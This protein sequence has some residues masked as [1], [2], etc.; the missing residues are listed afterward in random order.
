MRRRRP[1]QKNHLAV[2]RDLLVRRLF[3]AFRA[4]VRLGYFSFEV[5]GLE[6]VPRKGRVVYAQNHAGWFALDAFIL[7]LAVSKAHGIRRAPFFAAHDAALALPV[8]GSFMRRIGALPASSFRRPERLPPEVESVGIFPEGVEG[9]CKPF[10]EAYRMREWNRG[11][12]RVAMARRAPIVPVAMLGGE[13]S[14]P[15]AWT[16]KVLEPLIGAIVG[17][18]LVPIPLPARWKVIFHEPV[19]VSSRRRGAHTDQQFFIDVAKNIR[20]TV[21]ATLD[22]NAAQYPLGRLSSLVAAWRRPGSAAAVATEP[23]RG[24]GRSPAVT[25]HDEQGSLDCSDTALAREGRASFRAP[26]PLRGARRN[27]RFRT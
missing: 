9:N 11:F 3:P 20:G 12:V 22:R 2:D 13:E 24:A 14:L 7:T 18:P 10:W 6:H 19:R 26:V 23:R 8:L 16:V 15:V 27:P 17:F 4:L 5:Q 1:R 25:W 21:Q